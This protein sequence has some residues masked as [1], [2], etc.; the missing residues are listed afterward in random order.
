MPKT[1]PVLQAEP[2]GYVPG[3]AVSRGSLGLL[4]SRMPVSAAFTASRASN[5]DGILHILGSEMPCWGTLGVVIAHRQPSQ[6]FDARSTSAVEYAR[7]S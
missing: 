6:S 4:P 7:V 2:L 3:G 1:L 5:G